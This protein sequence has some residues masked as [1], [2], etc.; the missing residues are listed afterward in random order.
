MAKKKTELIS[1]I[2]ADIN[3]PQSLT[4]L[5][6]VMPGVI[7]AQTT[8]TYSA[9]SVDSSISAIINSLKAQSEKLSGLKVIVLCDDAKMTAQNMRNFLWVTFTRSNPATDIH[10]VDSFQANKHWGCNGPLIIDAR[11]KT[12]SCASLGTGPA[13]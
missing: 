10:G 9:D 6:L 4:D 8:A 11:I 12:R 2:P 5:N 7:A 13:D 3:W 1:S